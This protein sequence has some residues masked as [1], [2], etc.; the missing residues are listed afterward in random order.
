[1]NILDVTFC[2]DSAPIWQLVGIIVNV[3][4]IAIP[5]I[6]ILMAMVDLGKAV[7]AGKED[8]IK[9]AQKMLIKRLIYGILIFFVVTLVQT[10]FGLV[11][12]D[13]TD[14]KDAKGKVITIDNAICWK[15]ATK[16]NDKRCTDAVDAANAK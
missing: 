2:A 4:K 8:D 14:K 11:G 15:C 5:V 16:P 1:M 10:V 9:N 7:M 13:L 12:A 3:F 6:I